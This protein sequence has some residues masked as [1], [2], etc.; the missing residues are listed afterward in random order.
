MSNTHS[1]GCNLFYSLSHVLREFNHCYGFF[2]NT[3]FCNY[4]DEELK[5]CL[6]FYQ[7]SDYDEKAQ[8]I[9]LIECN[10]LKLTNKICING[11]RITINK[12]FRF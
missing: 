10:L 11:I 12:Y 8:I 1:A 7:I 5:H 6:L 2:E 3:S 9:K 4:L